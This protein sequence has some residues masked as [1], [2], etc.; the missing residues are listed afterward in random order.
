[1]KKFKGFL[2][3]FLLGILFSCFFSSYSFAD[4]KSKVILIDPGHGGIDGGSMSKSGIV[5]KDVNLSIGLKLKD[6]LESSGYT[7]YMTREDDCG[8]YSKGKTVKEK[9]R[10]DLANRSKMK[11]ETNCDIFISIHQNTFPQSKYKG[12][13][14][15]YAHGSEP[16]KNLGTLMQ[17]SLKECLDKE[18]N[19]L[20]KDSGTEMRVLRSNNT[21]A[22]ILIECGFLSNEEEAK[23]LATEEYQKKVVEAIKSG[24]ENYFT[25]TKDSSS[26]SFF[27]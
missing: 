27:H 2:S 25:A 13:Q 9:K 26:K 16:S 7:V 14:V 12:A 15:W 22:S 18:N 4:E 10:E 8:L 20:A 19:R 23:N 11:K 1:M 6:V 21:G 3:V 17:S 24:V 5:E